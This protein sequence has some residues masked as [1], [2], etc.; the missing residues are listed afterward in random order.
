MVLVTGG[1]GFVGAKIVLDWLAQSDDVVIS[2]DGLTTH[3]DNRENF[4]SF[5]GNKRHLFAQGDI[6][7]S[8]QVTR[9]LAQAPP[10]AINSF[11]AQRHVNRSIHRPE[12]F[13]P[14]DIVCTVPLLE[15][16]RAY[17][18]YLLRV[19]EEHGLR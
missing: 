4:S 11:A 3:P 19:I 13:I 12:D 6:S 18:R 15:A 17:G 1:A 5:N 16:A 9:F 14:A 10:R 8:T 7:D 2:L